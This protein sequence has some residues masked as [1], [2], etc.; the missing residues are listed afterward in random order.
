MNNQYLLTIFVFVIF[1]VYFFSTLVPISALDVECTGDSMC[2]PNQRCNLDSFVCESSGNYRDIATGDS[3][4]VKGNDG[5]G[6]NPLLSAWIIGL[7]I[8]IGF[9]IFGIILRK[10]KMI[11][12]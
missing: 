7:A 5:D 10:K 4:I 1:L 2:A 6:V 11:L 12:Y 8:I 3:K 9:I